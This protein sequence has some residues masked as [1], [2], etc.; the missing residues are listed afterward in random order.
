PA[1]V[2]VLDPGQ[3]LGQ[4][5]GAHVQ[6]DVRL[7]AELGAVLEELVG[8]EA[9]AV[10]AAPGQLRAPG[11]AVLGPDPVGPVVVADEVAARPAQHPHP[12]LP[13]QPEHVAAE[14]PRVGQRRAL[15][16]DPAVDA[17]AEVLDEATEHVAVQR[18]DGPGGIYRD[19]G[20]TSSS[21]VG[22]GPVVR[23]TGLPA[24]APPQASLTIAPTG[25]STGSSGTGPPAM[26][27]SSSSTACSPVSAN[28]TRSEVSDG[29]RNSANGMSSQLTTATSAGTCRPAAASALST[30]MAIV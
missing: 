10:H 15:L 30:P 3:R 26:R 5:P 27:R 11:P 1:A 22:A 2:A 9:V 17:A 23:F 12:Q 4:G 24:T 13:Q 18:A 25:S 8:A 20:H 21:S 19:S 28:G 16:V 29:I 14:P 7:G 6:A